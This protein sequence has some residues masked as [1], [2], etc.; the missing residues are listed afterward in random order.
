[1]IAKETGTQRCV[2]AGP[3]ALLNEHT[4]V[5]EG[6]PTAHGYTVK[7]PEPK[8]YPYHPHE[9][10]SGT[11]VTMEIAEREN[12]EWLQQEAKKRRIQ[13]EKDLARFNA[14]FGKRRQ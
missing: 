10:P 2:V 14:R 3:E 4:G 12:R 5:L 13:E 7:V 1:M 11:V 9:N 6:L 8:P